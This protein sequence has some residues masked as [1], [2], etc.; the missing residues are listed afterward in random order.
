MYPVIGV[1]HLLIAF[2]M[3]GLLTIMSVALGGFLVFRTRRD[4]HEPLFSMN[5]PKAESFVLDPMDDTITGEDNKDIVPDLLKK[6]T[7]RFLDQLKR[8]KVNG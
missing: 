8:E 3:G 2:G 4:S 1:W 5:S 7:D 6:Q